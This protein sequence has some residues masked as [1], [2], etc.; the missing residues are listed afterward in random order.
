MQVYPVGEPEL[1][2]GSP[3][4]AMD[5]HYA[6]SQQGLNNH[7]FFLVIGGRV[8][9]SLGNI[10]WPAEVFGNSPC[11]GHRVSTLERAGQA[12]GG[13]EVRFPDRTDNRCPIADPV[14]LPAL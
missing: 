8:A 13:V 5:L 11:F 12:G 7:G 14:C 2:D 3:E 9:L 6:F 1:F 4:V 10:R